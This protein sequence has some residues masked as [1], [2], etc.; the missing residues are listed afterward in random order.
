M[1]EVRVMCNTRNLGIYPCDEDST[2]EFFGVQLNAATWIGPP[3]SVGG[4]G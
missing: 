1:H 2:S 4:R 3:E